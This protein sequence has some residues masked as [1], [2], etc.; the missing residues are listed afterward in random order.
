M[1]IH[2]NQKPD[3][4]ATIETQLN[5]IAWHLQ[6]CRES[7]CAPADAV[8]KMHLQAAKHALNLHDNQ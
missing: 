6:V 7:N 4:L 3:Y 1:N 2:V 5:N 8:I